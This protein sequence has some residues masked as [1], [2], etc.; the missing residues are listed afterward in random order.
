MEDF[1]SIIVPVYKV[2]KYLAECIDSI[3]R[4]SYKNWE[5][6]LIDDGSPDSCGKICDSYAINDERISVIHKEN[7]G[8]S[9]ARNCGIEKARGN[10]I[11][12]IDS[13]DFVSV[14]YLETLITY[15]NIYEADIV[16]CEY[17]RDRT[18]IDKQTEKEKITLLKG[19]SIL[20]DYLRFNKPCV[21]A[22]AKIYKKELFDNLRFPIGLI[23]EDNF[24]TYITYYNAKVFVNVNTVLYFYRIN[25]T[26][27]S[28]RPFD[29]NKFGI[30]ESTQAI[31]NYLDGKTNI[32]DSDVD[33]YEMRELVQIYNNAVKAHADKAYP[34]QMRDIKAR[35]KVL[36]G[37]RALKK[38]MK[39]RII[40]FML[41]NFEPIYKS[42][43]VSIRH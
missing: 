33:Y 29:D 40:L 4:Q 5:L 2:E 6:I 1:V 43:V 17:S 26:S 9:D 21:L 38:E 39:Y 42:I 31:R 18:Q 24:T 22:C 20:K 41:T 15:A 13:D 27:I 23:D 8:L 10:Y 35:L 11:T 7:G 25:Q 30:L 36:S 34:I 12:F 28:N 32:F 37:D 16:Q 3:I 19:E 14:N